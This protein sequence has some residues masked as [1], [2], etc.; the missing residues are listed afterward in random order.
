MLETPQRE[1][2]RKVE[3]VPAKNSE[4]H[5][6]KIKTIFDPVEIEKQRQRE[7]S[8]HRKKVA[9]YARVST[10]LDEQQSSYETQIEFYTNFIKRN[11]KWDFAGIYSDEGITG[12]CLKN[13][14]GFNKMIADAK[15]GKID[16]IL[17]KSISRFSRNTIDALTVTRELKAHNVEVQFEKEGI[18]SMD[19]KAELIFTVM[20]CLAQEESRSL[21]ENIRWGKKR[22]MEAGNVYV[23]YK[24]FLGF[25]KGENG[26][27]E[28]VEDEA[29]IVRHIFKQFIIGMSPNAIAKELNGKKI[30]TVKGKKWT[31]YGINRILE[32]EKYKGD[33]RL[34]KTYTV[35]YLTK[36]KKVNNGEREQWYVRD[37]HDA[38]VDPR[39]FDLAQIELKRRSINRTGG[40][41][42]DSQY[43]GKVMCGVCGALYGHRVWHSGTKFAKCVWL[44]NDK[45]KTGETCKVPHMT[46][47]R[48]DAGLIEAF[49]KLPV[50]KSELRKEYSEAFRQFI[51]DDPEAF[52]KGL[53]RTKISMD[54]AAPSYWGVLVDKAIIKPDKTIVFNFKNGAK[55]TVDI[56]EKV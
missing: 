42:Y 7:E 9:A 41:V 14:T 30:K 22:S 3:V 36:K 28:I 35:D 6:R 56:N 53:K 31:S 54:E 29:K 19:P 11:P 21:S 33:A 2:R 39:T 13:R 38:I 1:Y 37:S 15:A 26:L 51:D 5:E 8:L 12:T 44:C 34:G 27:P 23:P 25:K 32:N 40:R 52:E 17:T 45:Y 46:D 47:R 16:L 24:S 55:V 48:L 10:Q 50:K 18:S 4:V 20:S 43:T 49:N